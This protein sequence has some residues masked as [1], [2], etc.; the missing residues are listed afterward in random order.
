LTQ[1]RDSSKRWAF[2]LILIAMA[3]FAMD[4]ARLQLRAPD[5]ATELTLP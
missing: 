1:P 2:A 4:T 3:L 5:Q